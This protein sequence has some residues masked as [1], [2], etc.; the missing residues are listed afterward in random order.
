MT[1]T[2]NTSEVLDLGGVSELSIGGNIKQIVG[3]PINTIVGF[4]QVMDEASGKPVWYWNESR[5][6]WFPQ[7]TTEPVILGTGTHPSM[8][9]LSTSVTYRGITLGAMIEAK[10]GAK[11]WS[12]VESELINRGHAVR[13]A[14]YRDTGIPVDGVYK[15]DAGNYVPLDHD[16]TIPY[17]GANF[18]NF[19]RYGMNTLITSYSI[20]DASFVKMRQLTLGYALP[21]SLLNKSFIQSANIQLVGHNL[22]D[23]VNHLPNGDAATSGNTGTDTYN[24]PAIRSYSLNINL[25]F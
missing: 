18:E 19:Y 23:I 4:E 25:S 20:F 15:N 6:V 22:F 9:G 13:T 21:K 1:Y 24:F 16:T 7:Q 14:E 12:N 8:G 5:G 3:Q 17:E 10:W 2:H 11:V